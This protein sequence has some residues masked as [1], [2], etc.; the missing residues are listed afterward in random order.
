MKIQ[1]WGT[2]A[3]EAIPAIFCNCKVCKEAREKGGKYLHARAQVMINDDLLVDFG[4]DTYQ[5][6]LKFGY[7]LADLGHVLITHTHEDHFTPLDL[8]SRQVGCAYDMKYETLNFYGSTDMVEQ[9]YELMAGNGAYLL[10][11][12]RVALN[13]VEPY[14]T[15]DVN[16][17]KVT[18]LPA[19]HGT[20]RP[21]VYIIEKDG[22]TIFY[23]NDSGYPRPP[24]LEWLSKCGKKFDLVSYDCTHGDMD[25]TASWGPDAG[26]MGIKRNVI[27]REKLREFGLYKPTTVD[28]VT[29]YSHNGISIRFDDITRIAKENGFIAA[30]DGM[31]LEI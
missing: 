30:Y 22:K 28:V 9:Y 27:L 19:T 3:A 11:Q 17:Y 13:V 23:C 21:F 18:P 16:G 20:R 5:S 6:S 14:N 4:P 10:E 29:H 1:Y 31:T 24:V 8:H 2:A 26:H 12:K 25:P 15:Y 7:N